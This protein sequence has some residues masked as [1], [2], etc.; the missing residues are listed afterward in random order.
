M[1]APRK[2]SAVSTLL[3]ISA[4]LIGACSKSNLSTETTV[5]G[6]TSTAPSAAAAKQEQK[7]LIRFLNAS[8]GLKDLYFRDM[9]A[10]TKVEYGRVTSYIALPSPRP[11]A[12]YE[13]KL[14]NSSSDVGTPLSRSSEVGNN[15]WRYTILAL[16]YKGK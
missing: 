1:I 9:P 14:Y 7:T 6:T 8:E 2:H 13:L 3:I 12:H 10:F 5:D 15:G 4:F 16:N 11:D